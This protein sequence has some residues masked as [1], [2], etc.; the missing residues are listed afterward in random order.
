[1]KYTFVCLLF[2]A[3]CTQ[4]AATPIEDKWGHELEALED[5]LLWSQSR[6]VHWQEM[7]SRHRRISEVACKSQDRHLQEMAVAFEK[8]QKHY[9]SRKKRTREVIH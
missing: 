3:A 1:M 8:Q 9:K 7:A 4:E 6:V 5:R 2:L